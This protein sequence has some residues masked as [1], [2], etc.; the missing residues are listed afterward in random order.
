MSHDEISPEMRL[1]SPTG[2][3]LYLTAPE[4]V[5]FLDAANHEK[6]I[7]RMFCHVL[8]YTGCRPRE[9]LELDYRRILIEDSSICYPLP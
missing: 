6:P 1:F 4:R 3:R 9:A 7:H 8:H 2:Q 5:R